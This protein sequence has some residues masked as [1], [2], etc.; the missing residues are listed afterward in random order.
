[1]L[2]TELCLVVQLFF[3]VYS[4]KLYHIKLSAKWTKYKKYQL[5]ML[6]RYT[7]HQYVIHEE[8]L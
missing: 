7:H 4:L 8:E 6:Y 2:F 1:M 3:T 5:K